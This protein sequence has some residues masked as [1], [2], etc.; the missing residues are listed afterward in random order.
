[1]LIPLTR[2]APRLQL[3]RPWSKS[4]RLLKKSRYILGAV[5]AES[6][7]DEWGENGSKGDFGSVRG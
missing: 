3:Y 7:E 6:R 2:A 1:M 4:K 5:S